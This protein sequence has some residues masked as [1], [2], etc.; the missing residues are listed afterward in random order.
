MPITYTIAIDLN[1]DGDFSALGDV[2]SG[3]VLQV[4]WHL[5]FARRYDPVA[6]AA[7][8]QIIVQNRSGKYAPERTPLQPGQHLRICSD[9]GTTVHTH[10]SGLIDRIEPQT[11]NQGTQQS[12][13][14]A[15]DLLHELQQHRVGMMPLQNQRADQILDAIIPQMQLRHPRLHGFCIID[16]AG[17][18]IINS[19]SIFGDDYPSTNFETGKSVFTYVGDTWGDGLRAHSA[20]QQICESEG[21]RF[22]ASRDGILTFHNRHH[23]FLDETL[24]ASFTDDMEGLRYAYAADHLSQTEITITPRR[25][26]PP[27]SLLWSLSEALRFERNSSR[28]IVA[29]FRDAAKNPIGALA[30]IAP[31]AFVH[32]TANLRQD[33][34]GLDVTGHLQ[35]TLMSANASA[36]VLQIRNRHPRLTVFL[37]NLELRGTPLITGDP[38]LLVAEDGLSRALHGLKRLVLDAPLL[39]DVEEAS[40][41]LEYELRRRGIPEGVLDVL[42]TSTHSHP[43]ETLSLTL[44]DRIRI[45]ESHSGHSAD[46]L[47][48]AE[49]HQIE[50]GG[51]RHQ[52]IWRLEPANLHRFF[53]V[54]THTIDDAS[55][56]LL[57]R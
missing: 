46:H 26:D 14:Y 8:A 37:Q 30:V 51:A 49:A 54:N 20:I 6:A 43:Q 34:S 48:I 13:I 36:A 33:G 4:R 17:H 23:I 18:N 5:G 25:I 29:R 55:V 39:Q 22:F 38:L 12:I 10:F 53:T 44:F 40:D 1:D 19:D 24:A 50:A 21:G 7:E 47:I 11:G 52:V 57:P 56:V 35:V 15:V 27:N 41:L 28:R 45:T 32:F 42:Q 3:D 9:D 31:Q 2:I 16:R